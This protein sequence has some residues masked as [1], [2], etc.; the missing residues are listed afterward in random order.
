MLYKDKQSV[1]VKV[2]LLP[3]YVLLAYFGCTFFGCFDFFWLSCLGYERAL[4]G[5]FVCA[6]N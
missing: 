2:N 3:V 1:K 5:C 6:V 4:K